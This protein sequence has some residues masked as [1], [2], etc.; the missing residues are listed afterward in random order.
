[1]IG[2]N[3]DVLCVNMVDR[4]ASFRCHRQSDGGGYPDRVLQPGT[5]VGGYEPLGKTLL[6]WGGCERVGGPE[7]QI[8]VDAY[9][10]NPASLDRNGDGVV[11]Y[12]LLEGETNHQDSLIRTEWSV[13]TQRTAV[14][15]SGGITRRDRELGEKPGV[16]T[17][18]RMAFRLRG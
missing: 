16:C 14:S 8:L 3:C 12:V 5:C 15:R 2:L 18:G 9:R 4:S 7:G 13:Q 11:S 17:H 10:K 6:C 1:M